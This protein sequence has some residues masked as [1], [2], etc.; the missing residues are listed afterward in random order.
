MDR[1]VSEGPQLAAEQAADFVL[2]AL[3]RDQEG[4][5]LLVGRPQQGTAALEA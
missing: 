1:A 2:N 5:R 4:S 3:V